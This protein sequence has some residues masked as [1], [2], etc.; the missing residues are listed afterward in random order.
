MRFIFINRHFHPD[1][2]MSSRLLADLAF[3]LADQGQAVTVVTSNKRHDDP[4]A[5]LPAQESVLDVNVIRI[6]GSSDGSRGL[7]GLAT[8]VLSFHRAVYQTLA[9]LV[10]EG[11][12]VIAMTDPPLLSVICERVT[13]K[14]NAHLVNW[15]EELYPE[16]TDT[17]EKRVSGPVAKLLQRARNRSYGQSSLNVTISNSMEGRV[18]DAGVDKSRIHVVGP[19]GLAAVD[20]ST[21]RSGAG[22]R[23]A[24]SL[25]DRF[26]IGYFGAL[27]PANDFES[28]L[29]GIEQTGNSKDKTLT[30]L[31]VGGGEGIKQLRESVP[32][33]ALNMVQF[34]DYLPMNRMAEG[35]AVPDV[36]LVSLLPAMEGIAFPGNL[37]GALA[38]GRPLIF[39]GTPESEIGSMLNSEGCGM[40]VRSGDAEGLAAAIAQLRTISESRTD[41]GERSR[42]LYEKKFAR[43]PALAAWTGLLTNFASK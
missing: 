35:L 41:M 32:M 12:V 10:K 17:T 29:S 20:Q 34:Q 28:L 16:V 26:V 30:W 43:K 6:D 8:E 1:N 22:L 38:S 14:K 7:P 33:R 25:D 18:R 21:V 4:I 39:I 5:T 11:D 19:W 42:A 24:W 13:R 37:P 23:K 3:H 40:V 31:F 9:D 2:S 27:N 36:H 15:L